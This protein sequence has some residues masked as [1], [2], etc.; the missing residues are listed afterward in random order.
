MGEALRTLVDEAVTYFG[1]EFSIALFVL[2]AAATLLLM[3]RPFSSKRT[4]D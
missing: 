1:P 3:A 4:E 2:I